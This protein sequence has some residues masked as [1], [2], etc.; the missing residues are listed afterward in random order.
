MTQIAYIDFG[1]SHKPDGSNGIERKKL[2]QISELGNLGQIRRLSFTPRKE[3]GKLGNFSRLLPFFPSMFFITIEE[4]A[5]KNLDIVY[6]R[7]PSYI[8]RY[9]IKLLKVIKRLNP[10]CMVFFELPTYPYDKEK[11]GIIKFPLLIKDRW[12]RR[13]LHHYVDRIVLVASHVPVVF[14]V[15][16]IT[17]TNGIDFSQLSLRKIQDNPDEVHAV[18]VGNFE[19]WH[20]LDRL[21]DGMTQYYSNP[22]NSRKFILHV[23]G[24]TE[25]VLDINEAGIANLITRNLLCLYGVLPFTEVTKVYDKVSLA[26][27]SLG[28]HRIDVGSIN[29]SVKSREYSA[30]GLPII[31]DTKIDFIP[32]GYEYFYKVPED[33][34][35]VSI[36]DIIEFHDKVYSKAPDIVASEI[37]EFAKNRC[38]AE[39][40][41][42]PVLEFYAKENENRR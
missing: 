17:I 2:A 21:I 12:H 7:K 33:N 6:F 28:I 39:A 34:T 38:S 27:S 32:D 24:P 30:K 22:A 9:T 10:Q 40:M 4:Q 13:K 8:D 31:S 36:E 14:N 41:M 23:V 25:R 1:T 37:R 16:T 18:I 3:R 42:R 11:K 35:V 26:F 19:F 5:F 29:S 20:G 15:P